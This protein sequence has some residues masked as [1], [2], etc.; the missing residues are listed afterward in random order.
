MLAP[1]GAI[2]ANVRGSVETAL[3]KR[4]VVTIGYTRTKVVSPGKIAGRKADAAVFLRVNNSLPL[5]PSTNIPIVRLSGMRISPQIATCA[6]DGKINFMNDD[7]AA[8][9]VKIGGVDL[10]T[11]QPGDTKEYECT[12][13]KQGEDLRPVTIVEWPYA[14]ATIFVGE[15]GV[16]GQL[17]EKGVFVLP[18]SPGKYE[19]QVIA[20]TGVVLRKD[21]E[22]GKTDVDVGLLDLTADQGEG[23]A[24]DP[25]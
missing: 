12:V 11:L 2:A 7:R 1:S 5:P 23:K 17:N 24:E 9:T 19:L 25:Q 21:V 15:V 3:A 4:T 18:G 10:G 13:G 6:V 16:A 22:L 20:Q 8:L 14:G